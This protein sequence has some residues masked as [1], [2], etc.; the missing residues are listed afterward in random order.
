MDV[1]SERIPPAEVGRGFD[2]DDLVVGLD[3]SPAAAAALRWAA[4]QLAPPEGIVHAARVLD[5]DEA[6]TDGAAELRDRWVPAAIGDVPAAPVESAVRTGAVA[7]ELLRLAEEVDAEAIVVGHHAGSRHGPRLVGHVVADLLRIADRPVV[8]VPAEWEPGRTDGRP[9]AVG[10]GAPVDTAD[11]ALRWALSHS[12]LV[13]DGLLL[14]HAYGPRTLFRPDGWF[15]VLAYYL[16]PTVP[17]EWIEDDLIDLADTLQAE[18]GTDVDVTVSV[19]PARTGATLVEAGA[20]AAV[21]VVARVEPPFVRNHVLAPYLRHAVVHAPC[22]I[23]IVPSP[24][25]R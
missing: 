14:V 2:R 12:Q 18:A 15:D 1:G 3:G 10:V 4:T 17:A 11:V 23:V 8:I 20:Q 21:L 22:P 9:A 13:R 6:S 19:H 25:P 5:H 24:E 7:E 16:D